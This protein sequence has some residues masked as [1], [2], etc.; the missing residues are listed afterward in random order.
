MSD[1]VETCGHPTADG[2]PCGNP[3]GENGWCWIPSHNPGDNSDNA[4]R[5][6]K[7][8]RERCDRITSSIAEGKSIVSAARMESVHPATV[9]AWIEKGEDHDTDPEFDVDPYGY[10][11]ERFV[12]ARGL[13]EDAYVQDVLDIAREQGDLSTLLSMLKQR[14][15]ESWGDV[16]RGEQAGGVVVN[17][18]DADEFEVDP[19]TLEVSE[20]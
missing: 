18:S 2:S 8:T 17:V 13:G 19:D 6:S 5:P 7:L 3:P 15:P 11:H 10:F 16:E 1:D 4:G 9:Y 12:R 14:Y 20:P